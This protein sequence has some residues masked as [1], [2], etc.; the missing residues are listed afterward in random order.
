MPLENTKIEGLR[1]I[2]L[3]INILPCYDIGDLFVKAEK[4]YEV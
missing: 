1:K 3:T 4:S 2:S